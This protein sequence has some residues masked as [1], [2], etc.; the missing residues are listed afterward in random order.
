MLYIKSADNQID[1]QTIRD[2]SLQK[3]QLNF[4][5]TE[6]TQTSTYTLQGVKYTDNP[7]M[8]INMDKGD[9]QIYQCSATITLKDGGEVILWSHTIKL[10]VYCE[11]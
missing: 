10:D 6:S 7:D 8:Q 1:K 4:P 3:F 9:N 5:S 2:T 11:Y